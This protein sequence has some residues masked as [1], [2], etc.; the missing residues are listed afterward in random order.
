MQVE[1]I[2]VGCGFCFFWFVFD[3]VCYC[4]YELVCILEV[5]LL[6]E[7][8]VFV[9][10]VVGCVGGQVV[11]GGYCVF[12]WLY[13]GFGVLVYGMIDVVGVGLVENGGIGYVNLV[14]VGLVV[15]RI[16]CVDYIILC[17]V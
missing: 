12:W 13:V 10:E 8:G 15:V 1:C 4:L 2:D 16:C 11:V 17:F 6:D 14:M 5:V 9:C 3:M 7:C